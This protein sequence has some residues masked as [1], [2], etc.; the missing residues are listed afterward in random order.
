MYMAMTG[1][2]A[3]F[4]VMDVEILF[5]G[6]PSKRICKKRNRILEYDSTFVIPFT[7][8]GYSKYKLLFQFKN[9]LLK[10]DD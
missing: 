4:I 2:T 8:M 7:D 3:P 10:R 9:H 6:I 5:R 1:S